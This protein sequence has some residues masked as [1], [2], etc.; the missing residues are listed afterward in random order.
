M[1]SPL[2]TIFVMAPNFCSAF[3]NA[4]WLRSNKFSHFPFET[5]ETLLKPPFLAKPDTQR[6]PRNR[7]NSKCGNLGYTAM[8]NTPFLLY[9][10]MQEPGGL[11][12]KL[13]S[14]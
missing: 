6:Y 5:N 2:L 11:I 1:R 8:A 3:S 14:S 9:C 13:L 12:N 4:L 7:C 10:P